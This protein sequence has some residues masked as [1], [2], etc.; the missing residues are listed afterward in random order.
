MLNTMMLYL[1]LSIPGALIATTI[2]EFT[3]AAVS[4]ALGDSMPRDNR[5]LTLNPFNHFEPIGLI[6]LVATGGFGWGKPVETSA[7]YYKDRKR[8]TLITLVAPM[9]ANI[10]GGFVCAVIARLFGS[11]LNDIPSTLFTY[12]MRYN[13]ALAVYNLLPISPMD[14]LRLLSY[15]IPSNKY[16]K[17]LQYEK[18]VQMIF[19]FLL[20][21]GLPGRFLSPVINLITGMFLLITGII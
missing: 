16:F 18:T 5:R 21:M 2:H 14:G 19:L 11:M 1:L 17:Y 13:V 12:A 6:L 7:L 10:I 15:I 9:A 20:F 3:R 8:D 4:T